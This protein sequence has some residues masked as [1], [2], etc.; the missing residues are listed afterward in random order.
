MTNLA[1][2]AAHASTVAELSRLLKESAAGTMPPSG[3]I[4]P[5]TGALWAPNL[6]D[7]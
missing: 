4:P 6:T 5:L 1:E 3:K 2:D 7:P